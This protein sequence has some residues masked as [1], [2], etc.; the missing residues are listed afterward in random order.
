MIVLLRLCLLIL[1]IVNFTSCE[2]ETKTCIYPSKTV[3]MNATFKPAE[4]TYH[5][6]DINILLRFELEYL[7]AHSPCITYEDSVMGQVINLKVLR[8]F[9]IQEDT[10]VED[11][12]TNTAFTFKY[13]APGTDIDSLQFIDSIQPLCQRFILLSLSSQLPEDCFQSFIINYEEL[14]GTKYSDS[15]EF[16]FVK[17]Q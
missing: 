7:S 16:V 10:L 12:S 3:G 2:R 15:T 1:L 14:D 9:I 17:M 11:I 5:Y 8:R 6:N 13:W 4:S